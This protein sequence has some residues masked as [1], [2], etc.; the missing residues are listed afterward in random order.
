MKMNLMTKYRVG[1]LN[2]NQDN[3]KI[4]NTNGVSTLMYM[5]FDFKLQ[6]LRIPHLK[7]MSVLHLMVSGKDS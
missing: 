6:Q 7:P 3:C 1:Y 2:I 5:R 4:Y